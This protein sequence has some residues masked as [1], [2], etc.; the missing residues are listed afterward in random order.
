MEY[1]HIPV[2]FRSPTIEDFEFFSEHMEKYRNK[3]IFIHCIMN[4]RVSAF[5]FLYHTI[6][7]HMPI[8]DA[9][10]HMIAVWQPEPV[11]QEFINN[12]LN[13]YGINPD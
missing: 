10:R 12:S 13:T 7:C 9:R 5:M 6:K 3:K 11:W 8:I 4:W 2:D 1:V